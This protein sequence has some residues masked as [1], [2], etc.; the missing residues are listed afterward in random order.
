[1]EN[2]DQVLQETLEQAEPVNQEA[3]DSVGQEQQPA[4]AQQK[5]SDSEYNMRQLREKAQRLERERDEYY[6]HLQQLEQQRQQVAPQEESSLAPDDLVEWKH[7]QKEL[8]KVQDELNSYKQQSAHISAE[9]RIKMQYPDFDKVVNDRYISVLREEYPELAAS[10]N[11]NPDLYSK[12]AAAYTLIKKLNIAPNEH[13]APGQ[14]KVSQNMDKPRPVSS[15]APQ[16]GESPL[17]KANAFAEGLTPELRSN[18]FKEM[19]EAKKRM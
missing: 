3:Q 8:K 5:E 19:Q 7:V 1:M 10:V 16:H 9:T 15:L 6:R 18:L 17:S 14:Q 13:Y 2:N 12:A 4:Y 11:A